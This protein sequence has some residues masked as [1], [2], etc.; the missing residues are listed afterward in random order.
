MELDKDFTIEE[1]DK[2]IQRG[3]LNKWPGPSGFTNEFF[4]V[5]L[6]ELSVWLLQAYKDSLKCGSLSRDAIMGTITC[7]PKG[8]K[9]RNDLKN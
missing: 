3:K 6:K 2:V 5:F 9:L 1:L 7:I 4:K 8:G